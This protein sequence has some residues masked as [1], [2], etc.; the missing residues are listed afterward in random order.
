MGL[1]ILIES[2]ALGET[3]TFIEKAALEEKDRVIQELVGVIQRVSD[4]VKNGKA[5][6]GPGVIYDICQI[7]LA[8]HSKGASDD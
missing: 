7:T 1:S 8:K 3:V 4:G 6:I 5:D 2:L